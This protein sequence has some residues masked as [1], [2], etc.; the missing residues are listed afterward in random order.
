MV[1]IPKKDPTILKAQNA[2]LKL[3]TKRK[4][5]VSLRRT[6]IK[7][8]HLNESQQK[9]VRLLIFQINQ[10]K[11]E[12]INLGFS[13]K[14][15]AAWAKQELLKKRKGK[16]FREIRPRSSGYGRYRLGNKLKFWR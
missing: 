7:H 5:L 2:A 11:K 3:V 9:Q 16:K 13:P 4:Q 6:F 10:F 8:G 1:K 12:I 15:A 14:D